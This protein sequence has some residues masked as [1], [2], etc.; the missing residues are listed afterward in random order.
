MRRVRE[1]A[2]SII[3]IQEHSSACGG[4]RTVAGGHQHRV[5]SHSSGG[6]TM[7]TEETDGKTAQMHSTCSALENSDQQPH[8]SQ[9][10]GTYYSNIVSHLIVLAVAEK[11]EPL[12]ESE[13]KRR[14]HTFAHLWPV[15]KRSVLRL[16]ALAP[17]RTQPR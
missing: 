16:P 2:K 3:R 9:D 5:H 17:G 10:P 15:P 12:A 7:S 1:I 6:A 13:H 11:L 8:Q 14:C 4:M